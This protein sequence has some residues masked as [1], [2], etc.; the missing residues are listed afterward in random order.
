MAYGCEIHVWV[1]GGTSQTLGSQ[2]EMVIKPV[3][4]IPHADGYIDRSAPHTINAILVD[5][6]GRDEVLLLATDSGNVCG[7][8]VEAIYSAVNR[9]AKSGYKR[10]FDGAEVS[11][12][13]VENVGMSAWGLATHKF[14][15]LI[16]VSANTGQITVYAFAL[17]DPAVNSDDS[18]GSSENLNLTSDQMWVSIDNRKQLRELKKLMPRNHR[19]RNLRLTYRGHFDNIPCVSFANF[20][21]DADGVW[22]VSTDINN[23]VIIWRIWDDLWPLRVY[24]PGHPMNNPPQRGWTVIPLDPRTFKQHAS[25]EEACGCEPNSLL[26]GPRTVLDVSRAIEEI[27]DSSQIFVFGSD[28]RE[29]ATP[30]F[31]PDDLISP[32]CWVDEGRSRYSADTRQ[33]LF[34]EAAC[35]AVHDEAET[36]SSPNSD[37][38]SREENTEQH[39]TLRFKRPLSSL[40]EEDYSHYRVSPC[41]HPDYDF[42]EVSDTDMNILRSKPVHR[43]AISNL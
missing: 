11:P 40:F 29:A 7:Y 36:I 21:L 33:N 22:M 27:P 6:L 41:L 25:R 34:P 28:K 31:L 20:D 35:W 42:E 19:S 43:K 30:H 23:R 4:K 8:H 3:M 12:F 14:A 13:F 37:M 5:D 1:P 9:C 2:A 15:R 17:V 24:Y 18:F 26:I 10:P 38:D 39:R 32:T 16:A